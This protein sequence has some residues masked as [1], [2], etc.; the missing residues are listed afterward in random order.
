[1]K[2]EYVPKK[3]NAEHR[4]IIDRTNAI[5]AEYA[6][7]GF[8]LTLRQV[9][10]QHVARDWIENTLQSYKRLGGILSDARRAGLIDWDAIEDRTRNLVSPSYWSTP[11]AIVNS[12]AEAY[13]ENLWRDQP[14][15][16]VVYVEKEALVGI[17]AA[18]CGPLR[19]PYMACRGY[20]SDSEIH[21]AARLF[22]S[23]LKAGR[24]VRVLHLG[25]H[26]PSG[27]DM[28]R[29][30]VERLHLFAEVD[31]HDDA[32][33]LEVRRIA[34]NADQIARYNPPPN[35]AK[36][37]DG[38]FKNYDAIHGDQSW[39]L[40]ALNPTILTTLVR[41]EVELLVDADLWAASAAAE[42]A[43]KETMADAAANWED[44]A[45]FLADRR[46][47][48]DLDDDLFADV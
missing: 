11:S 46:E 32:D 10:Y 43:N 23:Y 29:D 37:S 47:S 25:D 18:A 33:R 14:W 34:L 27:I 20:V 16:V 28:T 6:A 13:A 15:R 3:F 21:S 36:Q 9:F 40:D 17:I 7:Q 44:V 19:V 26:D 1:M 31:N 30:L 2:R 39:E 22:R 24:R 48:P 45:R 4:V 12:A 35:A 38:R 41:E 5:I 8:S 42:E